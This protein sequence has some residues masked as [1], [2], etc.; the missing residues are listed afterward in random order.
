MVLDSLKKGFGVGCGLIIGVFFALI[1][2][3]LILG[4]CLVAV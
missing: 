3:S 1:A 4:T 2:I